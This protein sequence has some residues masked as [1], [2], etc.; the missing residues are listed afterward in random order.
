MARRRAL[1]VAIVL[2][3][4]VAGYMLWLRNSSFVAVEEVEIAGAEGL[5]EAEAA[6]RAAALDQTTLNLD[7]AALEEAVASE[8]AVRSVGATPDFPHGLSITVE[9]R[10][11]IAYL[12]GEGAIVAGDGVVLERAGSRPEGLAVI[13]LG[14]E[15]T[16]GAG[17][18][19]ATG[20]AQRIAR[21][22]GAAPAPLLELVER[23]SLDPDLGI[24]VQIGPGLEL[25]FGD[26]SSATDKWLAAAAVLA[27]PAFEGAAY[28][29]LNVPDRPVAGGI[30]DAPGAEE[31]EAAATDAAAGPAA[32]EVAE[33]P[34]APVEPAPEAPAAAAP[35]PAEPAPA[36]PAA[37]A[38]GAETAGGATLE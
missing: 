38:T 11:P 27:D 4:L 13:A 3:A 33:T 36:A 21:V 6:L 30:P 20:D 14:G 16:G 34:A 23:G 17:A 9:R 18:G 15:A 28:L 12:K 26:A 35:A 5:P 32:D 10:E 37:P 19:A 25:R 24:V 31:L 7:L 29:D 22:L 1:V 8:P 2:A